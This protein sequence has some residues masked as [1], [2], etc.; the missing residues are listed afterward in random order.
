MLTMKVSSSKKGF[1]LRPVGARNRE[2]CPDREAGE[3]D[4]TVAVLAWAAPQRRP[5]RQRQDGEEAE[6]ARV[7]RS[8]A[9]S[10]LNATSPTAAAETRCRHPDRLAEPR[11]SGARP[12]HDRRRHHQRAA[13]SPSHQVTQIGS[14]FSQAA[15][16][17]VTTPTVALMTVAGPTQ[18]KANFAT[19]APGAGEG[20]DAARPMHDQVSAHH[21]LRIAGGDQRQVTRVPAVVA[22]VVR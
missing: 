11:Q 14:K 1:L 6:R 22:L 21:R 17:S 10:G 9:N 4:A 2:R 18:T 8:A 16:H 19:P 15:T 7:V 13:A 5:A 20:V 3:N 12:Q